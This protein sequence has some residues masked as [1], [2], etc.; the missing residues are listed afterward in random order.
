MADIVRRRPS[1]LRRRLGWPFGSLFEDLFEGLEEEMPELR[2]ERRFVPAIDVSESENEV[3][4]TAE[5]PG[6]GKEDLEVTV[7]NGVLT[8]RGEKK[9]EEEHEAEDFHRIERR[10]GR[11]ERSVRL[12]EYVDAEQ[13]EADYN[14]GVLTLHMPKSERARAKQ[15]EIK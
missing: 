12:P 9:Q 2:G 7:D 14:D 10:Y 3:T 15:I 5:V 4:L 6:M 1:G 11:F 13:I 8:L